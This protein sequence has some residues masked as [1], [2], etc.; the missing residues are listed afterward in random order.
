M[1]RP[2][3]PSAM[4]CRLRGIGSVWLAAAAGSLC[5]PAVAWPRAPAYAQ[6]DAEP[7]TRLPLPV[8]EIDAPERLE[9]RSRAGVA[10][11]IRA[12]FRDSLTGWS[13]AAAVARGPWSVGATVRYGAGAEPRA[14]AVEIGHAGSGLHAA[15]G[16]VDVRGLGVLFG[17]RLGLASRAARLPSVRAGSPIVGAPGSGA[18]S[19]FEGVSASWIAAPWSRTSRKGD[20]AGIYAFGV[21]RREEDSHG[22]RARVAAMGAAFAIGPS[23]VA[24]PSVGV[25]GGSLAASVSLRTASAAWDLGVE[26]LAAR[27]GFSTLADAGVSAPPFRWRGRWR[28]R[29]GETRPAAGE[30]VAEAESRIARVVVRASGGAS[31]QSGAVERREVE[32]RIGAR[33]GLGPLSFR[34]G[35]TEATGFTAA[36]GFTE[37]RERYA[38]L[39][40]TVARGGGRVF[41]VTATR[42]ARENEDGMK[43][44]TSAGGRLGLT[45]RRRG[46][47]EVRV[48]AVR[49]EPGASAWSSGVYAGGATALR[50]RT[51][52]GVAMSARGEVRAGSWTLGGI[53]EGRE[54]ERG[55]QATAATVWIEKGIPFRQRGNDTR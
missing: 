14:G 22:E 16:T 39:D 45:W 42:R 54:D 31:G 25:R 17:E 8:E 5:A 19:E 27:D 41:A 49:A 53:V 55:R 2:R 4:M 33:R 18:S 51:R 35:R 47:L 3:V 50:S 34:F 36:D 23:T 44:G 12:S 6:T 32:G 38:V 43:A 20:A 46:R 30:V 26:T 13:T 37:R 52:P 9:E 1:S 7:A 48:E 21:R 24:S 10:V 29:A 40:L 28:F 15:A 11:S